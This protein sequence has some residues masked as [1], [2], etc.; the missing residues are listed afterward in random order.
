M[1]YSEERKSFK[2]NLKMCFCFRLIQDTTELPKNLAYSLRFPAG[3]R[4]DTSRHWETTILFRI[5]RDTTR[6]F[7]DSSD[8]YYSEGFLAMQHSIARAFLNAIP[9]STSSNATNTTMPPIHVK[10]FPPPN[11]IVDYAA[12]SLRELTPT[13][14]MLLLCFAFMNTV[15]LVSIEKEKQLKEAMKIMGLSSWI[16][17]LG[18]FIRTTIMLS[19]SMVLITAL[20]TV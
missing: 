13:F 11:R 6:F 7:R 5:Y 18:W 12:V 19:I 9:Q 4:S 2:I 3:L 8:H 10:A 14:L 16:H 20:L 15:R 1:P 17:Y